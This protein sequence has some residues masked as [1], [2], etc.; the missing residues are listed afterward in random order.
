MCF[1]SITMQDMTDAM[2]CWIISSSPTV[3]AIRLSR[4]EADS[5]ERRGRQ[6]PGS[7]DDFA[8][9]RLRNQ[10]AANTVARSDQVDAQNVPTTAVTND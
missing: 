8:N 1:E 6:A 9:E 4:S 7:M 5:M 3:K 2:E 10:N